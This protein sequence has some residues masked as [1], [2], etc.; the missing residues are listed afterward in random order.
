MT[1]V[2]CTVVTSKVKFTGGSLLLIEGASIY[3][4]KYLMV[5]LD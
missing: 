3:A 5:L 1:V 4:Q 2:V